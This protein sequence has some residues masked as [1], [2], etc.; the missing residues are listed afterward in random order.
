M[1]YM[2]IYGVIYIHI[3]GVKNYPDKVVLI[4]EALTLNILKNNS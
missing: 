2:Y 1:L 4:I 3:Y